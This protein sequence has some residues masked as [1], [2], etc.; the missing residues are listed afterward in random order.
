MALHVPRI[1]YS[2]GFPP[3]CEQPLSDPPAWTSRRLR[4]SSG[5]LCDLLVPLTFWFEQ[6]EG[7]TPGGRIWIQ[8]RRL[9]RVQE[10][11]TNDNGSSGLAAVKSGDRDQRQNASSKPVARRSGFKG[12]M[13][14]G[15]PQADSQPRR[16]GSAIGKWV[17]LVLMC[18]CVQHWVG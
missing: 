6:G 10:G 3:L 9:S 15:T 2:V 5:R 18:H 8:Q 13:M 16:E 17:C 1:A 7:E 11:G 12:T 4:G 14:S